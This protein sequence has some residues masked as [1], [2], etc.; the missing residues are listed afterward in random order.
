MRGILPRRPLN[1]AH[2]LLHSCFSPREKDVTAWM[3][4]VE[5]CREQCLRMRAGFAVV[6]PHLDPLPKGEGELA[7]GA[8]KVGPHPGPRQPL[9]AWLVLLGGGSR[10]RS[11]ASI[12]GIVHPCRRLP[13]GEGEKWYILF[14]GRVSKPPSY[15]AERYPLQRRLRWVGWFIPTHDTLKSPVVRAGVNNPP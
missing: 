13:R 14:S 5:Q 9:P 2:R 12:P 3:S 6:C 11:T 1:S 4:E 10:R 7:W 8:G 15:T